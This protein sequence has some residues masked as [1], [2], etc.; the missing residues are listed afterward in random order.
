MDEWKRPAAGD[1]PGTYKYQIDKQFTTRGGRAKVTSLTRER[2][3]ACAAVK[4]N[5]DPHA[6]RR[7]SRNGWWCLPGQPYDESTEW[8]TVRF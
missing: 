6:I 5:N 3:T 2:F 1:R 4:G 7:V 8:L